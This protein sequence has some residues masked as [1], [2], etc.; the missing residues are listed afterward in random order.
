MDT[1]TIKAD[2]MPWTGPSGKTF[3][4]QEGRTI[5]FLDAMG[6]GLSLVVSDFQAVQK[7]M[8]RAENE[9]DAM[10]IALLRETNRALAGLI[11]QLNVLIDTW[12]LVGWRGEDIP[13][14]AEE[15]R[16]LLTFP[17]DALGWLFE[18]AANAMQPE[19]NDAESRGKG[20]RRSRKPSTAKAPLRLDST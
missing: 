3:F 1:R 16:V 17:M 9:S 15:P 13:T 4:P 20:S 8:E 12:T 19:G 7:R 5:T 14:P 10:K 6:V 18:K 11:E 2:E